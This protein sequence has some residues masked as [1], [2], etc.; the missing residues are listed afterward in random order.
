M[1]FPFCFP[2]VS[3]NRF[4]SAIKWYINI[5]AAILKPDGNFLLERRN[6]SGDK[7]GRWTCAFLNCSQLT[8]VAAL[9]TFLPFLAW[10][11]FMH[12][13]IAIKISF[14]LFFPST[15][16]LTALSRTNYTFNFPRWVKFTTVCMQQYVR[17]MVKLHTILNNN[18]GHG[19][20]KMLRLSLGMQSS[21]AKRT[22][23]RHNCGDL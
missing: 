18:K 23:A 11:A 5:S 10:F 2:F 14:L 13:Q 21:C 17:S 4:S 1:V 16:S 22:Y 15:I 9:G 19:S 20:S 8:S 6:G 12:R 7:H 3:Q